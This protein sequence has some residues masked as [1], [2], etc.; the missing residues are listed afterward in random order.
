MDSLLEYL[1]IVSVKGCRFDTV[2]GI[3]GKQ[4]YRHE[5]RTVEVRTL[6]WSLQSVNQPLSHASFRFQLKPY[7]YLLQLPVTSKNSDLAV[8][9]KKEVEM[10]ANIVRSKCQTF[11]SSHKLAH[12]HSHCCNLTSWLRG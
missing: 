6:Q 5:F 3:F 10:L 1:A 7:E 9:S 11:M 8:A 12:S 4:C 2:L